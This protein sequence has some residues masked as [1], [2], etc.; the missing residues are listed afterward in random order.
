VATAWEQEDGGFTGGNFRLFDPRFWQDRILDTELNSRGWVFQ[1][2]TLAP[3][4]LHLGVDQLL[5]D[6]SCLEAS[7]EYPVGVES[8]FVEGLAFKRGLNLNLDLHTLE[9]GEG[10][11]AFEEGERKRRAVY[12]LWRQ[13]VEKYTRCELKE[14]GDKLVAVSGIAKILQERFGD[15]YVVGLWRGWLLGGLCWKVDRGRRT[16]RV[17]QTSR[18]YGRRWADSSRPE[19]YR[20]PSWSWASVEGNV[21]M[22]QMD[23][24]EPT[25]MELLGGHGVQVTKPLARIMDVKVAPV[26]EGDL[27]G[28]I[29]G[30][31]I[32]TDGMMHRLKVL[33][34]APSWDTPRMVFRGDP[35]EE[36]MIV[37]TDRYEAWEVMNEALFMPLMVV[38][39]KWEVLPCDL[40]GAEQ[41]TRKE[42]E[43]DIPSR[44]LVD[45]ARPD[46]YHDVEGIVVVP[47]GE[48]DGE[49][50]RIGFMTSKPWRLRALEEKGDWVVRGRFRRV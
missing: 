24:E 45:L 13:T 19:T 33:Y 6:C 46:Y 8:R 36:F 39:R 29:K 37:H 5:F 9:V 48:K 21:T 44:A 15:G 43:R 20:A 3:R 25:T 7:E 27:L 28:K 23:S 30:A 4:V 50:K 18:A 10:G 22:G 42:A 32:E 17:L 40:A 16:T 1:E 31:H 26:R 11:A 35:A 47:T 41:L 38:E 49:Y 2:R 14:E 12:L 34:S